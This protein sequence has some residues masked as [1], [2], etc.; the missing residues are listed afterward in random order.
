MSITDLIVEFEYLT[1]DFELNLTRPRLGKVPDDW[2]VAH[3]TAIFKK[4]KQTSPGNYR[5]VSLTSIICKTLESII[6]DKLMEYLDERDKLSNDQHGFRSGRSCVT[7]LLEIVEV[8]SSML[9]EGAGIDVVYL[10]FQKAF[11]SVPHQRLLKK[12][13]AYGIQGNLLK[14]IESFL[15]GRK[16]R[17]IINGGSSPWTDA[18]SGI[19]KDSVLGPI[20]FLIFIDDLPDSVAGLVKIFADDTK[21]FSAIKSKED[22]KKLQADL[23][24]LSQ[25]SDRWLSQFNVS[26]C[27][28]MHYGQQKEEQFT[29][30]MHEE[31]IERELGVLQEEKDLGVMFDPTLRFSKHVSMVANKANRILGVMKRTFSFM[32]NKML[33][34]LYKTLVRPHVEYANCV[35]HPFLQNDIRTIE[36]VQRRA[37]KLTS[38]VKDLE[39][40]DRLRKLK[41]PTLAYRRLRGDMIQVYKIV[42][43][44]IGIKKEILFTMTNVETGTR[45]NIFKLQKARFTIK[46]RENAFSNR[47]VNTWNKL[48]D[49]VVNAKSV[50]KFKSGVDSALSKYIDKYTY[51]LGPKWQQGLKDQDIAS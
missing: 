27:G 3:V 9:D 10:D 11:D 43:E 42:H 1:V 48:P 14:W 46:I 31:G 38:D 7:Q 51:G 17:V 39:Y 24:S 32:D 26:K 40:P 22:C 35:W 50:N 28:V 45:G 25:W 33:T 20:L 6:R 15:T 19:P 18:V 49:E 37:T 13:Y 34:T 30:T 12:A 16:Q 47:V 41:L 4:G 5:P 21:L 8:C 2:K 44:L 36:K 23:E 29:Y